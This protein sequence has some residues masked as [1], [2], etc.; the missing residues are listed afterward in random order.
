MKNWPAALPVVPQASRL[1]SGFSAWE[2]V[3]LG[4]TP[5][6]NWLGTGFGQG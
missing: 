6:L 1:P 4:R 3:L 5:H 2:T